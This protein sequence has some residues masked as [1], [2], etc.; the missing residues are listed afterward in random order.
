MSK[1]KNAT[2]KL[3][4]LINI[5][6][7]MNKREWIS[8][9]DIAEMFSI[10]L[11]SVY[12]D[13]S[14]LQRMGFEII[15]TTGA[16]GGYRLAGRL[17]SDRG[18]DFDI[19]NNVKAQLLVRL[20]RSTIEDTLSVE[21]QIGDTRLTDTVYSLK[22]RMVFDVS[23]WYW[24]DGIDV[25]S[26]AL[27]RS[28][29]NEN[30]IEID[31]KERGSDKNIHDRVKPLGMAWKAGYWY[32]ICDS[33]RKNHIIRIRSSRIV[34]IV[35]LSEHF[36]YPSDFHIDE[37]WK[38]EL[39]DFGRGDIEVVLK[40]A[41]QS[42]IEEWSKMEEKPDTVKT[43]SGNCLTV[44][45]YVDNWTWLIPT[46]LHYGD[47]VLV[48]KPSELKREIVNT[49]ETMLDQYKHGKFNGQQKGGFI[50]DDSRERMSK[51]GQE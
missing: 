13:I 48:E 24:K 11:R 47:A 39:I 33:M 9:T 28:I 50:N 23:D 46:I 7:E 21:E 31:Y 17:L 36:N 15:G 26:R 37:W 51:S 32:L 4:R 19:Y 40:I 41:G 8:A 44:K 49:I 42:A 6:V 16:M 38:K 3:T 25:Y 1:K 35:E 12:R 27:S 29:Q 10:S 5:L 45:Y 43:I 20:G 34:K 30:F 2:P 18:E 14:E 22:D